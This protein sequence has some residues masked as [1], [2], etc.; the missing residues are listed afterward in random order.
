MIINYLKLAIRL[1]IRNPFFTMINLVCLSVGFAMFFMLW[2]HAQT[3]LHSDQFHKD[4]ERI[5]RV[6]VTWNWTDDG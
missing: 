3:E 2:Q 4:F 5:V 1:L 6:G